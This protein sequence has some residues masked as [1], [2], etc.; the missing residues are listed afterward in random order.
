MKTSFFKRVMAFCFDYFILTLVLSFITMGFNTDSRSFY[1]EIGNIEKEYKNGNIDILEYNN[2]LMEL[3]Y[4]FQKSNLPVNG[5]NLAL[6]VGYFIVFC[7][8]NKGQTLGKKLFKIRV[9]DKDG[10]NVKLSSLI[11]RSLFIY[12]IVSCI[13]SIICTLFLPSNVFIYSYKWVVNIET[14]LL[15]ACFLTAMYR[16]DGKGLH[17]LISKT[18][19]IGE[20]K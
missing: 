8:L 3:E 2:R 19:V 14:M 18:N 17:D 5:I 11:V 9:V 13:Y 4:D 16:K 1:T 15:F 12:G 20:V 7:Y 10:G 6:F